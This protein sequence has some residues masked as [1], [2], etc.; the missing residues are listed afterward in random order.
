MAAA[1]NWHRQVAAAQSSASRGT[2]A[3][4][5]LLASERHIWGVAALWRKDDEART[6][7]TK[8]VLRGVLALCLC[9]LEEA[10]HQFRPALAPVVFNRSPALAVAIV[11]NA[12]L[13]VISSS[14]VVTRAARVYRQF[15]SMAAKHSTLKRVQSRLRRVCSMDPNY[16]KTDIAKSAASPSERSHLLRTAPNLPAHVIVSCS[17]K[18]SLCHS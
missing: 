1:A 18:W 11:G 6:K 4:G 13:V 16:L 9:L 3:S 15:V 12:L 7:M 5:V 2:P 17:K 14:A 8:N 10:I